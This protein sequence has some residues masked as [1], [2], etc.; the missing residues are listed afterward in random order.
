MP[1]P[2]IKELVRDEIE[3]DD[4]DQVLI[5]CANCGEVLGYE[6]DAIEIDG[7]H[8]HARVNPLG[9]E[10]VFKCFQ[11]ALG[12]VIFGQPQHADTWFAGYMWELVKCSN[13]EEHLGWLFSGKDQF[14]GLI[15]ARIALRKG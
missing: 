7:Q 1:N 3:T 5:V 4:N 10:Y 6:S 12:C 8:V 14:Y 11:Q 2:D 15:C 9:Y 13:C